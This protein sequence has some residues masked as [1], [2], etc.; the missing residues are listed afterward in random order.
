ME[1]NAISAH[2]TIIKRNGTA[3]NELRDITP[4]P[5]SRKAIET[6][7]HNSSDDSYVVGIR[8]KG[9]LT[10][11]IGFLNTDDTHDADMGLIKAWVDGSKDLYEILYP[12]GGTWIF[13]GF[14]SNIGPKQP[15]DGG[16]E[17]AISVR[18]SGGHIFS[19]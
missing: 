12:D 5:L 11:M 15:V 14:V 6:T 7:N 8:R 2:G 9:D 4:P 16:Q 19:E 17:A 18:P 13:S 1:S 10:F 3:I